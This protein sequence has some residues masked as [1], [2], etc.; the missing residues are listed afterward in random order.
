MFDRKS[1]PAEKR[2]EFDRLELGAKVASAMLIENAPTLPSVRIHTIAMRAWRAE[3]RSAVR[4]G[5]FA[6]NIPLPGHE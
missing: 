5:T 4:A 1:Y 2:R 3:V 6:G